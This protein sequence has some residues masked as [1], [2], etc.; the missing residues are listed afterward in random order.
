M[1][2]PKFSTVKKKLIEPISKAGITVK[3][4]IN[5]Y[6][7][8]DRAT[9]THKDVSAAANVFTLDVELPGIDG[10]IVLDLINANLPEGIFVYGFVNVEQHFSA[11]LLPR[12]ETYRYFFFEDGLNLEG[13]AAAA[14]CLIGAH[15]FTKLLGPMYAKTQ[16]NCHLELLESKIVILDNNSVFHP[17]AYYEVKSPRFLKDQVC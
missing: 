14:L 2:N 16:A 11:K 15:D 7:S 12:I 8:L 1:P 6:M 13:M 4:G 17:V 10:S 3:F 9:N 5:N